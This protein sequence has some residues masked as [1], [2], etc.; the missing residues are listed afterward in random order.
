MNTEG[1][2]GCPVARAARMGHP[3]EGAS[4]TDWW[5]NQLNLKILRKHH[6]RLRP[7]GRRLRLRCGVPVLRWCQPVGLKASRRRHGPRLR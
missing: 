3:I 2:A 7:D 4:N 5:P 1:A 6:G